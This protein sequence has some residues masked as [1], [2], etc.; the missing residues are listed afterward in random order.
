M[1]IPIIIETALAVVTVII[2][3]S[4]ITSAVFELIG[5]YTRNRS[6]LLREAIG[7]ALHD[8]A[9]NKNY[10]ELLYNHPQLKALHRTSVDKPS[11]VD[12]DTFAS[13]L[14]DTII[15]QYETE[16]L[17]CDKETNTYSIPATIEAASAIQKLESAVKEMKFTEVGTLLKSFTA[18]AD[19]INEVKANISGWYENFMDRV[20][21]WYT[22]DT[23]KRLVL[24][25][26]LVAAAL[27]VDLINI[28]SQ[29]YKD[30]EIREELVT[31]GMALEVGDLA[32]DSINTSQCDSLKTD[33]ELVKK[34]NDKYK[35]L[36]KTG[37]S[38][39]WS[40]ADFKTLNA[41]GIIG[42]YLRLLF[43]WLLTAIA[44]SRG[45]PF[46]FNVL[47]SLINLRSSGKV[48]KKTNS[49]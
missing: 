2:L 37:L 13:A 47:S 30:A 40:K 35:Q 12:P 32:C 10:G 7:Q 28:T 20:T 24:V 43:G 29:I 14:T 21:G 27:N 22:R 11:Y 34:I 6:K 31:I 33:K 9:L 38:I 8:P 18:S 4:I 1:N 3:L 41:G 42:N 45:A 39:G 19:N 49:Q 5:R 36:S 17:R 16:N 15:D 48:K 44:L 25:G 46:W 26:F 23:Q